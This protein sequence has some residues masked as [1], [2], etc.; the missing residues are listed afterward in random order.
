VEEELEKAEFPL[1][2]N[3]SHAPLTSPEL[4]PMAF[5]RQDDERLREHLRGRSSWVLSYD[6]PPWIREAYADC[7]IE[8]THTNGNGGSKRELII[9]PV[10]SKQTNTSK[11]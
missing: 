6:D 3:A 10:E 8:R 4:Y 1:P 2:F 5:K 7:R 11:A 9:Q